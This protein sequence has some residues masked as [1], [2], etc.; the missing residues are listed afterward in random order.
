MI[1]NGALKRVYLLVAIILSVFATAGVCLSDEQNP[2]SINM[3][4]YVKIGG[5]EQWITIAGTDHRNPVILFLHGGPGTALSPFAK[6]YFAGWE[7]DFTLV[8]WDQRGAGKTYARNGKSI[9]PTM[10]LERMTED[11][12]EVAEYLKAHLHKKKIILV[13]GS[14]GSI[15]GARMAHA[16]PDLF[17]A[18]VGF[19]QATNFK[20]DL[21]ASYDK[22][23]GIAQSKHDQA[24]LDTLDRLGP[25]P[26]D[27]IKK[28]G[29][30]NSVLQPYQTELATA[31]SPPFG[32]V[33]KEYEADFK[34]GGAWLEAN[35]FSFLHFWGPTLSGPL[36]RVDITS[37]TD[38]KIPIFFVLGE[39][40]LTCPIELTRA[41]F[42]TIRA[43]HKELYV[44]PAT[45]HNI[46]YPL[47]KLIRK[48]LLSKVRPIATEK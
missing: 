14:W 39:V 37:L 16:R 23:R 32:V 15:L 10:T 6:L 3:A 41:Y 45:G 30:Y 34:P 24:A 8:Q 46:S 42:K 5:I 36:T 19:M 33:A 20:Q 35:R 28:W 4:D 31:P 25:P 13:G 44:A 47:L 12:I 2:V 27:S 38:F 22:L 43:P 26:W 11:G 21:A 40:D 48:V 7:K 18:Y 17:F 9:E 1:K 29:L